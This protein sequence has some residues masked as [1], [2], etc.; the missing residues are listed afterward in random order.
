MSFQ[1]VRH[2]VMRQ[3][4]EPAASD[5][6]AAARER[7]VDAALEAWRRADGDDREKMHQA[8]DAAL[9]AMGYAG[10]ITTDR[11]VRDA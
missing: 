2:Q 10:L 3:I 9:T 4:Y 8:L 6:R 5:G 1:G 7:V 11:G